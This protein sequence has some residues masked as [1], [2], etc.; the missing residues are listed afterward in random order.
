MKKIVCEL[1]GS[2]DL[3]KQDG[4]YECQY[5]G[6]KY[7]VEEAKKLIIEGKVKIDKSEDVT[8]YIE[9][10]NNS[11]NSGN[12]EEVYKFANKVLEIDAKNVDGWLWKMK[13]CTSLSTTKDLKLK[14]TISAAN[15]A[16]A[17]SKKKEETENA[18][19][20]YYLY[21]VFELLQFI[22]RLY[23]D[24]TEL[25]QAFDRFYKEYYGTARDQTTAF[26]SAYLAT[27]E[28]LT[29]QTIDLLNKIPA[30][31]FNAN[32]DQAMQLIECAKQYK[33]MCD[34]KKT[35][36]KI[37]GKQILKEETERIN[38]VITSMYNCAINA[39]RT[40]NPS[41]NVEIMQFQGDLINKRLVYIGIG[42]GAVIFFLLFII[43]NS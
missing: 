21:R 25:R 29:T 37:Y 24:H 43:I 10:C 30:T 15:N 36:C 40:T 27:Y 26:D 5:C 12:Y 32:P 23:A 34:A 8:N 17:N 1:C 16:I 19:Y 11:F 42:L 7:S 14:E 38:S 13:G 3:K 28:Q 4:E 33:Y 35:R 20:S 6:T 39:I 41:F 9:M 31:F 22:T 2:N 18:V